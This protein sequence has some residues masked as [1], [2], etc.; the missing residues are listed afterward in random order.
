VRTV[1]KTLIPVLLVLSL[2]LVSCRGRREDRPFGG[3][4]TMVPAETAAPI[5]ESAM[6]FSFTDREKEGSYTENGATLLYL[7]DEG[8]TVQ[9]SGA[10]AE[11]NAVTVTA[12]GTYILSGKLSDGRVTV[13]ADKTDKIQLVLNNADITSSDGPALYIAQADKV[14]L[15]LAAGSE[16][17]LTDGESYELTDD[18][19][20]L[21][22]ALFSREDLAINGSGSL[23]V[24][25]RYKHGIVSK[26]DLV[27][28]GGTLAVTSQKVGLN[29]KDCV[30]IGGGI[31]TV[32]A[33]TDGLRSDNEKDPGRGYVY[34]E[35]GSLTVTSGNDGIQAYTVLWVAGGTLSLTTG[36]G[37]E[38]ASMKEDGT[39]NPG[40]GG[41]WG[42]PGGG[43]PRDNG[44]PPEAATAETADAV[45][46][47]AKGLKS[48]SVLTVSG[49]SVL[50]DSSDDSLHSNGDVEIRGGTLQLRSGDDGVHANAT[51]TVSAGAVTV[52]KSYEGLEGTDIL[53]KGGTLSVTASDDGVNA[54]GGNDG[55]AINGRPGMGGFAGSTGSIAISGGYLF[56]DASGDGIDSNG[57]FVLS[58]GVVLVSGPTNGGNGS[59]DYDGSATVKG[60]TLIALGSQGMAQSFSK[61]EGQG[62]I[63]LS[64]GTQ[65]ANT[66]IALCDADG[67]VLASFC[68]PKAYQTAVITAPGVGKGNR[69][70][71]VTGGTLSGADENG[72]GERVTIRGGAVIKEIAMTSDL[73]GSSGMGG[74]GGGGRPGGW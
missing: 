57:T 43:R 72:Y 2:V 33:G 49:G 58:G 53:L 69:F 56:V 18:D 21:D 26:D 67:A 42:R 12:A 60:G 8:T 38:N 31:L 16:N 51:L 35:D 24:N 3:D 23:T 20:V 63:F 73:Y 34:I 40:W 52:S 28:T 61:A 9:G 71:V 59:F 19:T 10:S 55:S 46:D 54:A 64:T 39:V 65:Q 62:A 29:G 4:V 27:I 15:T 25:G 1:G 30:K 41:D 7:S 6:D 50:V 45:S 11:G 70:T 68:P 48:Y 13:R 17:C 44:Y 47:S 36:G 32:D 66:P 5:E 74:M 37:S 22:A 14:F